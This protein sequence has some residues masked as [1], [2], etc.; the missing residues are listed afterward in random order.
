MSEH[1]SEAE[2]RSSQKIARPVWRSA[3]DV[4]DSSPTTETDRR[5][6]G[7]LV[8][9]VAVAIALAIA[10]GSFP[11]LV[12]VAAI[13]LMIMLHELGHFLVAKASGMKVTEYFLG[14]GPRLWAVRKGETEYGVKALPLGGY[15]RIVG[16][17]NLETVDPA[18]E[19]RSYR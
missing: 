17:N 1:R 11:T 13:V 15:V 6:L 7:Q 16:M 14:F 5:R 2:E 3:P 9:I 4:T 8:L 19:D 12:V 18:D 10:T